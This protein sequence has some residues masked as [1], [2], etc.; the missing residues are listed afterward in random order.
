METWCGRSYCLCL[1]G[2]P[3]TREPKLTRLVQFRRTCQT[4]ADAAPEID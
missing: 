3:P 4:L 2:V 1:T